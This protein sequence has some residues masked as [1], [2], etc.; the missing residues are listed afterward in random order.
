MLSMYRVIVRSSSGVSPVVPPSTRTA[1]SRIDSRVRIP[2]VPS[3]L[4]SEPSVHPATVRAVTDSAFLTST[5]ASYNALATDVAELWK[6]D[7]AG[8]P[9]DRAIL[10]TF[11]ELVLT[12]GGGPVADIGCGTGRVTGHLH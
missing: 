3:M 9:L 6:D 8:Q 10:A 7:L 12:A 2:A 5:R 11:A 4:A 1:A